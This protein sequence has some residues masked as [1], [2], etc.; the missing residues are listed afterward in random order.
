MRRP[1]KRNSISKELFLRAKKGEPGGMEDLI[2]ACRPIVK[3][4]GKRLLSMRTSR[5]VD[6]SDLTQDVLIQMVQ[7]FSTIAESEV[8]QLV[9]W[10]RKVLI[11][12]SIA[13]QKYYE[14]QKRSHKYETYENADF[15]FE[16]VI[17]NSDPTASQQVSF[18]ERIE[19]L[20]EPHRS[21]CVLRMNGFEVLEI[22]ETLQD[23]HQLSKGAVFNSLRTL[24]NIISRG[25]GE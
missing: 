25:D 20:P 22:V 4:M 8:G 19:Q 3:E 7:K 6:V 9:A 17:R 12:R 1:Q 15:G 10:L 24:R 5:K 13:I 18:L 21:V 23:S 11:R 14:S 2:V 16:D